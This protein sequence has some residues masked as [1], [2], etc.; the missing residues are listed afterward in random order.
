MTTARRVPSPLSILALTALGA[1]L[2]GCTSD[3]RASGDPTRTTNFALGIFA[4][5][6]APANAPSAPSAPVAVRCNQ[7]DIRQG[8]ET[9][10]T[11]NAGGAANE[12]AL[13]WQ[14]SVSQ[15]ARECRS[16]ERDVIY[17]LG[18]QGRV[19]LGPAGQPGTVSV[20]LRIVFIRGET[21]VSSRVIR[22]PVTI[23][24]G[25][26]S[27]NFTHVADE[28]VVRRD[29]PQDPLANAQWVVGFDPSPERPAPRQRRAS[30]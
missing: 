22:I 16:F 25:E 24:P 11:F 13:R 12:D 8:T 21:V 2:A 30:R 10:R 20:P 19:V 7:V 1:V 23:A 5:I 15:V 18:V 14:V 26:T 3:G 17:N 6:Q 28:Q 29:D 9:L 27:A 4:P